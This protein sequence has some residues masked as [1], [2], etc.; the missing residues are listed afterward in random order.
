[1]YRRA[2]TG[3]LAAVLIAL[4]CVASAA[5][6]V[7][8]YRAH[9]NGI[10]RGYTP[11]L[12]QI[13]ADAKAAERTKN[14]AKVYYELGAGIGLGLREDAAVEAVPVPTGL[15]SQMTPILR[16]LRTIDG[17]GRRLLTLARAGNLQGVLTES[18][19]IT[20]LGRPLDG[21]LDRAGLAD[22]GSKQ[23]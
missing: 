1:M 18:A 8:T 13:E 9:V 14:V 22:C 6:S 21:M 10:C 12:K 3:V 19:T 11:Q 5:A 2:G 23:S 16:Q 17:H 4:A 15:A 7:A 20:T